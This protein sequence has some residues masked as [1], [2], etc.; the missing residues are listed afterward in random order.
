MPLLPK[1]KARLSKKILA[2]QILQELQEAYLA[3]IPL[4]DA[5]EEMLSLAERYNNVRVH[6][7]ASKDRTREMASIAERMRVLAPFAS[8]SEQEVRSFLQSTNGGE[9]LLGL[10]IVSSTQQVAFF[11]DVLPLVDNPQ[12]NYEQYQALRSLEQLLPFLN[13]I[14]KKKLQETLKRIPSDSHQ[15]YLKDQLLSALS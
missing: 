15:A 14:Q 12:S 11:D 13:N 1:N 2:H 8:F 10:S 6:L 9:R 7:P 3:R 4:R 5:R